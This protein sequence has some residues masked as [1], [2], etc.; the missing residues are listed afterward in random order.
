[1]GVHL[2]LKP[3]WDFVLSA[4]GSIIFVQDNLDLSVSVKDEN[5]CLLHSVILGKHHSPYRVTFSSAA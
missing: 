4:Y 5:D 1:M 3:E 2:I